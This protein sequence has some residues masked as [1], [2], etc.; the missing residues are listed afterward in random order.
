MALSAEI[1]LSNG[2]LIADLS[3]GQ[4]LEQTDFLTMAQALFQTGVRANSLFFDW[5][6]GTKMITAGTR[7]ALVAEIRQLESNFRSQPNIS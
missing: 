6:N 4:R 1:I 7:V 3:D 5:R 2:R